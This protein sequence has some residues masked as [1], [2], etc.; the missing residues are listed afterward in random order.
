M[1]WVDI[2]RNSAIPMIQQIYQQIR[3]KI[4]SGELAPG[5]KMPSSRAFAAELRISRNVVLEA[6]DM[7]A[8][9]GY[10]TGEAGSGTYVSKGACLKGYNQIAAYENK[11][12]G[13]LPVKPDGINF[14]SGV[15]A[16]NLFPIEKWADLYK[17]VCQETTGKTLGYGAPEGSIELRTTLAEYLLRTRGMYC[18]PGSIIITTGAVQGLQLAARVLISQG[19]AVILEDPSNYDLQRIFLSA[20]A[21]LYPIPV[22]NKGMDTSLL[23]AGLKTSF[24]Y[25]TPSHQFPMGGILPIQRRIELVGYARE[26]GCYILEDDYDSEFRYEGAP[27]GTIKSLDDKNVIYIGTFSK[28]LFPSLRI[29]YLVLPEELILRFRK[30]KKHLDVQTPI[31]EQLTLARFITEGHL[32]RHVLK[33]RKIYS[34]RRK[35]LIDCLNEFFPGCFRIYGE[36]AGLHLVVEFDFNITKKI[37]NA[38]KKSGIDIYPVWLHSLDRNQK[39]NKFI[40]GYGNLNEELIYSGIKKLREIL[41]DQ[42]I[43]T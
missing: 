3:K 17:K 27:V 35:K 31:L 23:P 9:E 19:D 33:V 6:Y 37:M 15:P 32:E 20:G 22:D 10:L 29:G 18:N 13:P 7:L 1:V 2:N 14:R 25:V 28:I 21:K 16:L 4:L 36:C 26:N 43:L 8:A 5:E 40:F 42:G 39:R 38:V 30:L 12:G 34:R 24:I 11:T 41:S